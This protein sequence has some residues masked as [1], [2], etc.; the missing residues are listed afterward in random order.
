MII[1]SN[2]YTLNMDQLGK[3]FTTGSDVQKFKPTP[4]LKR[5]ESQTP[6]SRCG[7]IP[8]SMPLAQAPFPGL[9]LLAAE[10]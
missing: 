7:E 3:R 2:S 1:L 10:L 8:D 6:C 9:E 4:K 5:P